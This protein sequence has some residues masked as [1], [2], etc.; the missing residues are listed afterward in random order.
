MC[1]KASQCQASK[2]SEPSSSYHFLLHFV[3]GNHLVQQHGPNHQRL[4]RP[5]SRGFLPQRPSL[6]GAP[7]ASLHSFSQQSSPF[8]MNIPP[9]HWVDTSVPP[10]LLLPGQP[11][12]T[13]PQ[14]QIGPLLQ[15]SVM[16]PV[17]LC[18]SIAKSHSSIPVVSSL[19]RDAEI[20]TTP[21][22]SQGNPIPT[23]MTHGSRDDNTVAK[24]T[25]VKQK[26]E[27]IYDDKDR[28]SPR[29]FVQINRY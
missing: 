3:S 14:V 13:V 29:L 7:T 20:K 8:P 10:P 27:A 6:L 28:D 22:A 17:N 12:P 26:R 25:D 23:L 19:K 1:Q 21:D 4:P 2:L 16:Q 11:V 5:L 15:P 9:P 24:L 18:P